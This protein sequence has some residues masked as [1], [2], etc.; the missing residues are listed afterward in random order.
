MCCSYHKMIY[1]GR[2]AVLEHRGR[3]QIGYQDEI[4]FTIPMPDGSLAQ[5]FRLPHNS[6]RTKTPWVGDISSP[7][8]AII[9]QSLLA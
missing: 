1:K 7:L 5:D 4:E 8:F 3:S 2:E 9:V 6:W